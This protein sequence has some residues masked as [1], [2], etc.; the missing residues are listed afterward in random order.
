MKKIVTAATAIGA[1]APAFAFAAPLATGFGPTLQSTVDTIGAVVNALIPIAF[2]AALLFFF[3]GLAKYL[4]GDATEHEKGRNLMIWGVIALAIMASVWGIAAVLR[5][6][7][8]VGAD[9]TAT[10]PKVTP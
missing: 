5:T 2:A 8:G 10:V 9:T 7:F 3:W 6:T 1:F 4:L